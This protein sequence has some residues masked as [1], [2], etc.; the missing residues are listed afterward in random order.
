MA[1][2]RKG[3]KKKSSDAI[4]SARARQPIAPATLGKSHLARLFATSYVFEQRAASAAARKDG[5][6]VSGSAKFRNAWI[7][8]TTA[9]SLC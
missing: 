5:E 6:F 9:S 2:S 7:N 3:P 8:I 4:F 1:K